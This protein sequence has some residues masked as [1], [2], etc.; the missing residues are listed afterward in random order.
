MEN[1]NN[2]TY[3]NEEIKEFTFN[4]E[5]IKNEVKTNF[6]FDD[7]D[8]IKFE[9]KKPVKLKILTDEKVKSKLTKF[10]YKFYVKIEHKGIPKVWQT[11]RKTLKSI[12]DA[13]QDGDE[14]TAMRDSENKRF[15]IMP[16]EL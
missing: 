8:L 5:E 12:M 3:E 16:Y 2:N 1:T 7:L 6:T 10:G 11:S 9:D 15:L 4:S 13:C 14:I